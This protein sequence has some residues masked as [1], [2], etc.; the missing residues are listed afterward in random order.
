MPNK[1]L[2]WRSR[3]S[4]GGFNFGDFWQGWQFWQLMATKETVDN[5]R[6]ADAQL[7]SEV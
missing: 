3:R 4:D 1:R 7:I 5:T 6:D 2:D